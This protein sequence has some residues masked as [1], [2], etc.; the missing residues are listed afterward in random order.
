MTLDPFTRIAHERAALAL[1]D[2][3]NI[4]GA[5]ARLKT[6]LTAN[7]NDARALALMAFCKMNVS[8]D[9]E[10]LKLARSAA[11]FNPDDDLVRRALTYALLNNEQYDE[12]DAL[13]TGLAA[14]DPDDHGALFALAAAKRARK[15]YHDANALFDEAQDRARTGGNISALLNMARLRLDQW[16]FAEA[17]EM[18][19]QALTLDPARA[20]TLFILAECALARKQAE[21][22]YELA[23]EALRLD[24]NDKATM[25]LLSR[26]RAR[27]SA[28]M[29]PFLPGV[30]WI[31]EMDRGGIVAFPLMLGVLALCF[32]LSALND[33]RRA[34][35]G[36]QSAAAV[37]V[38]LGAPLLYG[39]IC[40]AIAASTR[41]RIRADLKR[42]ALPRF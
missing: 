5:E 37:T 15:R 7:P 39:A 35:A 19:R 16:R 11:T 24:P 29:R 22:A 18:A 32:V 13:A 40:Y 34:E 3:G 33:M 17:E 6:M 38:V 31:V 9:K 41:L 4:R 42:I 14:D 20:E 8:D 2:A 27:R 10:A 1:M 26:A 12:A 36:L 28:W 23:L 30:D 21:E 25:R